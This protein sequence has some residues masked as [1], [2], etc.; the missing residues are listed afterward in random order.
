MVHAPQ[1][2]LPKSFGTHFLFLVLARQEPDSVLPLHHKW[3]D[4]LSG[5]GAYG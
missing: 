1:I 2:R 4:S 5:L 3:L